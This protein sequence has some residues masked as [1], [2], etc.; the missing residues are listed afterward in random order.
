MN[1]SAIVCKNLCFQTGN[2]KIENLNIELKKGFITGLIGRNGAGK[3]T[4]IKIIANLYERI[5]GSILYDGL[6]Y[7]ENEI[8]IKKRL[9]IVYDRS[10]FSNG[11]TPIKLVNGIK[12][13]EPWFDDK[14]FCEK[15]ELMK[16]D[17][18]MKI[19]SFS[20]GMLKKL[21]LIIALSRKPNILILDELTSEIDPISRIEILDLLQ[22]FMENENNT[23]LF[24][25]HITSDLDKIADYIIMIDD[26]S[27]LIFEEKDALKHNFNVNGSLPE[28]ETIMYSVIKERNNK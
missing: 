14:F 13:I 3:T 9:S 18:N 27:I 7:W 16:L 19:K 5:C 20:K 25:T 6:N 15:M 23:I 4:L 28:I 12:T 21:M 8:E 26:G 1:K 17:K 24:S 11:A 10:N 22:E 2:F